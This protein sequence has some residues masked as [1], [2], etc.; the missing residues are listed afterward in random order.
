[1]PSATR[2]E[3]SLFVAI[4]LGIVEGL[5]EFLPVSSTG[6]LILVSHFLG[7][8][9]D[10][11]KAFDIVVQLGAILAVVVHYRALFARR[12]ADDN[13]FPL[14]PVVR[15]YDAARGTVDLRTGAVAPA[16]VSPIDLRRLILASL[17]VPPEM[18]S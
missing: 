12:R 8:T 9:D 7:S 4:L 6:H 10:G 1:M 11:G 3:V 5:T 13:P 2:P 16:D 14:K 18:C 17:P 15:V